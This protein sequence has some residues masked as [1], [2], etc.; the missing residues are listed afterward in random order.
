MD[1]K[2]LDDVG[3]E[4]HHER[5]FIAKDY[6]LDVDY[7]FVLFMVELGVEEDLEED[8]E[9]GKQS[10][11]D[12]DDELLRELGHVRCNCM[13]SPLGCAVVFSESFS[14]E[15]VLVEVAL[16]DALRVS[17]HYLD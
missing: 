9:E 12:S 2:R 6:A 14:A 11:D 1:V 10:E 5:S 8:C 4:P 13:V 7:E 17:V 16:A 15:Q 3:E